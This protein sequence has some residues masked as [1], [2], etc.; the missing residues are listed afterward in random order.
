MATE[1]ISQSELDA[2]VESDHA[3]AEHFVRDISLLMMYADRITSL[4]THIVMALRAYAEVIKEGNLP[5][6]VALLTLADAVEHLSEYD[7]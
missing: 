3:R 1:G 4:K 7:D 5:N 6:P 2:P